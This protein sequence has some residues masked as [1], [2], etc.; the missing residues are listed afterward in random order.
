MPAKTQQQLLDEHRA[1]LDAEYQAKY[2]Q[3]QFVLQLRRSGEVG[4]YWNP[5]RNT[6]HTR[7][8]GIGTNSRKLY[9]YTDS[10]NQV[11]YQNCSFDTC[12]RYKTLN[13]LVEAAKRA[14]V[15]EELIA[16]FA[17]RYNNRASEGF[18]V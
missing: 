14:G 16:A 1:E 11:N 13:K 6:S 18:T 12:R 4:L 3:G 8:R 15:N 17:E 9:E 2:P 5:R 7:Y 10:I